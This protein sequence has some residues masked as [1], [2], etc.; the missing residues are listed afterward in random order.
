[1]ATREERIKQLATAMGADIKA[2]KT[3]TGDLSSLSTTAKTNLV[4]AIN[5]L[6]VLANEPNGAQIDD[7]AGNGATDVVWSAD[8]VFDT[9]EAAKVA[10]KNDLTDGAGTALDT[11]KEL[12]DAI[13]N[14]PSF[15]ATI[16][17]SLGK[18]V[19]VDAAQTFTAIEKKQGAENLGLGDPDYDF[20]VDYTAAKV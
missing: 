10:V 20:V 14:D 3:S 1:M 18:R 12:G 5:E 8:K 4:A 19:R 17:T 11:L 9:I 15:A 16:A 6:Y 13:G 2:L 7:M